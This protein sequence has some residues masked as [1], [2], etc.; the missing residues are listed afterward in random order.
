MPDQLCANIRSNNDLLQD[1]SLIQRFSTDLQQ[2]RSE[3]EH[4][5]KTLPFEKLEAN[6]PGAIGEKNR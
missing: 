2:R 6:F 3:L 1:S 5:P 4:F